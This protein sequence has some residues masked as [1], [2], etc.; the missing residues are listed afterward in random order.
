MQENFFNQAFRAK[1]AC[2]DGPHAPIKVVFFPEGKKDVNSVFILQL[3]LL[4]KS[5]SE[6][7]CQSV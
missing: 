4:R 5:N 3:L 7:N 2:L 1:L 6:W